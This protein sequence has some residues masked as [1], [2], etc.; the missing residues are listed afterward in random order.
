M[1][2]ELLRLVAVFIS[3]FIMMTL[4]AWIQTQVGYETFVWGGITVIWG[5]MIGG[6]L[7]ELVRWR[8][9]RSKN[10]TKEK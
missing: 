4:F 8:I 2:R 5:L 10:T 6:F 7:T 3:I 9:K 1:K